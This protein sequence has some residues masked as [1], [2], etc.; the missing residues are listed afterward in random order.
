MGFLGFSSTEKESSANLLGFVRCPRAERGNIAERLVRGIVKLGLDLA[1]IKTQVG[2]CER[3]SKTPGTILSARQFRVYL[4][5]SQL[6]VSGGVKILSR[7]GVWHK[8][9]FYMVIGDERL[10]AILRKLSTMQITNTEQLA[11]N[12]KEATFGIIEPLDGDLYF[13][14]QKPKFFRELVSE[15]LQELPFEWAEM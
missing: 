9:V 14:S 8:P 15:A 12:I 13:Y 10:G 6:G 1:I 11:S 3:F 4:V 5:N 7:I 2:I